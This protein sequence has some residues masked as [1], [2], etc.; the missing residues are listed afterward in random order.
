[1]TLGGDRPSW[2]EKRDNVDRHLKGRMTMA[3]ALLKNGDTIEFPF[4]QMQQFVAEHPELI[5]KQQSEMPRRRKYSKTTA[6]H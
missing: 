6:S 1:M 2:L 3:T 4:E 5:E